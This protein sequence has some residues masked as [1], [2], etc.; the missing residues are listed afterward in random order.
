MPL[1]ACNGCV[2]DLFVTDE[3][4]IERFTGKELLIWGRNNSGNLGD[5]T[6]IWRS[7]PVQTISGGTNWRSIE[8]SKAGSGTVPSTAAG[9]KT[10]GTLWIWGAN[11]FGVLG[12]NTAI[13]AS[14]PVQTISAGTNW[15]NISLASGGVAAAT[16]TDGTLWTWG[17]NAEGQLGDNTIINKSSPIQTI[18]SGTNWKT[19]NTS[20]THGSA[21]KTDG[22][23]WTWGLGDFG[24]LGNNNSGNLNR[25]S[26]PI[27]TISGGTNWKS[28][29]SS[30]FFMV[31]LKTDGTLWSWG[32]ATNGN[33]GLNDIVNRSTPTQM[34]SNGTMWRSASSGAFHS[35]GIKT[36]GTLWVWGGANSG[37]LGNNNIIDASSPV[38]TV[39]GGTNWRVAYAAHL[40]T[41]AIKTDGTLWTWGIGY[42]GL[43]GDNGPFVNKSSPV[44]TISGGTNWRTISNGSYSAGATR[45]TEL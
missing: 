14:S 39:S 19:V 11:A 3:E 8:I 9:I 17:D 10:D 18:S 2:K 31:A 44:Q 45:S 43:L 29:S 21:I 26:S 38:Q 7:S 12:N 6:V 32:C 24:E 25:R 4:L 13:D 30:V 33:L 22:T 27:Q 42:A 36:D 5:Q 1:Y 20:A 34:A 15:K 35:A 40:N 16:K 37:R 41:R 23:L 28:A